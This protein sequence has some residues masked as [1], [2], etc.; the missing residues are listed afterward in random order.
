MVDLYTGTVPNLTQSQPDFD[1][2]T[3]SILDYIAQ[4]APQLNEWVGAY[5]Q[6]TSTTSNTSNSIGTGSK[7]FTVES[8][9]GYKVN[10]PVRASATSGNYMDGIVTAYSGTSLTVNFA[11][12][13][14]TGTFTSWQ[15]FLT[16]PGSN[17]TLGSNTFTGD[18][19]VPDEAYD[20][21]GW[22]GDLSV[23][24]KNAVRDKIEA[25]LSAILNS[26][27][28]PTYASTSDTDAASPEWVNGKAL[29]QEGSLITTS[30]A[31]FYDFTGIPAGVKRVKIIMNSISL[32]G[33]SLPL[34]QIGDSGGIENTGYI[35]V[36]SN[37]AS[38]VVTTNSTTGFVAFALGGS[39]N[40]ASGVIE[41]DLID[42]ATNTFI[43]KGAMQ[44]EI[45]SLSTCTVVGKKSLSGT[46]TQL[47][48]T[49]ASGTDL[50]DGGSAK[51]TY[52]Y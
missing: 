2:N 14:G 23:P 1:T 36:S 26:T 48:L 49:S 33:S 25:I 16:V 41:I 42:S 3:Q 30:G 35:S 9:K 34:I 5:V 6:D 13:N 29:I 19:I 44:N 10:M 21:T 40:S 27:N 28:D 12:S 11:S 45:S 17:V 4:F 50:F 47:R 18:Q 46:L 37:L 15:I 52:E 8:G 24:T 51:I 7:T 20:A 39:P 43:A 38:G 32:D 31:N 22:N